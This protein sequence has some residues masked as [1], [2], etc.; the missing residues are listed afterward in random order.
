MAI[1][2]H[3]KLKSHTQ[4][5]D[6]VIMGFNYGFGDREEEAKPEPNYEPMVDRFRGSLVRLSIDIENRHEERNE[7]LDIPAH[8]DFI[9][10]SS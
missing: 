7:G 9:E 1:Q 4:K 3:V 8:Y 10:V 6:S 5:E 2:P